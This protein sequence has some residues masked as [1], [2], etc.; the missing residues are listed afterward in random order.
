V[1]DSL[2]PTATVGSRRVSQG[3]KGNC[4]YFNDQ[5]IAAPAVPRK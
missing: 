1:N 5:T 4:Q 2:K 3:T